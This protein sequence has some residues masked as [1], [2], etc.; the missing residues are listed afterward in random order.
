M[1]KL[2]P[3]P[4]VEKATGGNRGGFARLTEEGRRIVREYKTRRILARE[5]VRAHLT[6]S[7][8]LRYN[9]HFYVYSCNT[10]NFSS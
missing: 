10:N 8:S 2:S 5:Q 7:T 9:T 3:K 6:D 4:L 1:N